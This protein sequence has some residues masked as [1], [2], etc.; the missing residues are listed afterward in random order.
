[1]I[2]RMSQNFVAC[3]RE[4]ELS[5]PPSLRELLPGDHLAWFVL[6]AV[7]ELDLA[8][9]YAAYRADGPATEGPCRGPYTLR[10]A[11]RERDWRADD[12]VGLR[13]HHHDLVGGAAELRE[14]DLTR[15]R[16]RGLQ[17]DAEAEDG[18]EACESAGHCGS[19]AP[20]TGSR[21]P[22][23][24]PPGTTGTSH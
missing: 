24:R 21:A 17:H 11:H 23:C 19:N 13:V 5:L 7:E 8:A 20:V 1:M 4:Q 12:L 6:A 9:F 18:E 14:K 10:S 2:R 22:R 15:V 16:G 3:D